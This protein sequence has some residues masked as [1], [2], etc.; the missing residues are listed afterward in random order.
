VITPR[1]AR[2]L[3]LFAQGRRH[4]KLMD[5]SRALES[6]QEAL[7]EDPSDGPSRVY[8]ERCRQLVAHPPPEDWDG[9]FVM[10]TK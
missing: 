1:K 9:V 3:E 10:E 4:Y 6:F 2:V 7:R 5:F 8:V